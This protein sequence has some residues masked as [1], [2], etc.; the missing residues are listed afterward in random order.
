MGGAAH[1][2][3]DVFSLSNQLSQLDDVGFKASLYQRHLCREKKYTDNWQINGDS[4]EP[5]IHE[6]V[7]KVKYLVRNIYLLNVP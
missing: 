7:D 3:I 2:G 4:I 6:N 5:T 1:Y